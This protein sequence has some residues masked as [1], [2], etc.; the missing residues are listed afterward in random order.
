MFKLSVALT[1]I[2]WLYD[3]IHHINLVFYPELKDKLLTFKDIVSED[4]EQEHEGVDIIVCT[5]TRKLGK[6]RTY[7]KF[8]TEKFMK[9][10]EKNSKN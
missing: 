8:M 1:K 4:N 10:D 7:K 3:P 5:C 6:K 2:L 9:R